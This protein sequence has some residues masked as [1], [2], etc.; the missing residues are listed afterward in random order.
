MESITQGSSEDTSRKRKR[1]VDSSDDD[2]SLSSRSNGKVL[3]RDLIAKKDSKASSSR[4]SNPIVDDNDDD[5][6]SEGSEYVPPIKAMSESS[7]SA[8][9][10]DPSVRQTYKKAVPDE[11][12]KNASSISVSS[13]GSGNQQMAAI[14]KKPSFWDD[15]YDAND[16]QDLHL[17]N[18]KVMDS[19]AA[20]AGQAKHKVLP[21]R[22]APSRRK[23]LQSR[24][25]A[26]RETLDPKK[27]SEG[28]AKVSSRPHV[29]DN[30]VARGLGERILLRE[31]TGFSSLG[32]CR[33]CKS[34]FKLSTCP[35][36]LHKDGQ[37]YDTTRPP[38]VAVEKSS[39]GIRQ[40]AQ[41]GNRSYALSM[42]SGVG[43]TAITR[44]GSPRYQSSSVNTV[45]APVSRTPLVTDM[46][47]SYASASSS[48]AANN[49]VS[50]PAL[51]PPSTAA[52]TPVS[53]V[54][55]SAA[56]V[57]LPDN[58]SSTAAAT[59]SA[60]SDMYHERKHYNHG[61]KDNIPLPTIV[62][63]IPAES[64]PTPVPLSSPN[65]LCAP[66][67]TL[68]CSGYLHSRDIFAPLI[69]KLPD[70]VSMGMKQLRQFDASR[71]NALKPALFSEVTRIS[72]TSKWRSSMP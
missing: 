33:H 50:K 67:S 36:A 13:P 43:D 58:V 70:I 27:V 72:H 28:G 14:E 30:A 25:M 9:P 42:A 44:N 66:S 62:V 12:K 55:N 24:P 60:D 34:V 53:G 31:D 59:L 15:D 64:P 11:G 35:N 21:G 57:L 26:R 20:D 1:L 65:E 23:E 51:I 61:T 68:N 63:D 8:A 37:K 2:E 10:P 39:V 40:P 3:K 49:T 71:L 16:P 18:S 38:S 32:L 69:P 56:V 48:S 4:K 47:R 41:I 54:S 52:P 7:L 17:A 5:G 45:A 19:K 22:E 29:S 6:D 46:L